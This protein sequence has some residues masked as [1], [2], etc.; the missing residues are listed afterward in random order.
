MTNTQ[1]YTAELLGTLVVVFVGSAAIITTGAN[2]FVSALAF[3]LSWAGMWWVFGNVSGGH[4]N[5]AITIA[6]AVAKRMNN[7]DV[8]PYVVCQAIGGIVGSAL[9]WAVLKGAPTDLAATAFATTLAAPG[10]GSWSITSVLLFEL[11]L[12]AFMSLI[13]LA[14]TEKTN[15]QGIT[16]LGLGLGYTGMMFANATTTWS[17]LNPART[18]GPAFLASTGFGGLWVFWVAAIA[19]AVVGAGIWI[20]VVVPARTTAPSSYT[21]EA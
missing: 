4:F 3:G 14:A 2:V 17:A 8:V 13:F 10:I 1:K 11:L 21:A 5:P 6:S 7:K 9:V 19:G 16:G 15:A 18:L 20:A 12:T